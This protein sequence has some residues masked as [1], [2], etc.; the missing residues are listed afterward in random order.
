METD[1]ETGLATG[2][3]ER[4]TIQVLEAKRFPQNLVE[5]RLFQAPHVFCGGVAG[6]SDEEDAFIFPVFGLAN[7]PGDFVSGHSGH[8][9]IQQGDIE[10]LST[11]NALSACL[12][13]LATTTL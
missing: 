6:G 5:S 10:S 2:A 12:P 1:W 3:D 11:K 13:S 9:L 4:M 8:F 7:C